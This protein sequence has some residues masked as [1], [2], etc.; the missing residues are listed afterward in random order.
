[1]PTPEC[2]PHADLRRIQG[3]VSGLALWTY[4]LPKGTECSRPAQ[5][6][7]DTPHQSLTVAGAAQELRLKDFKVAHLFP[8]WPL[9]GTVRGTRERAGIL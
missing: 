7:L 1:M 3:P 2:P 4:R 8:V 9:T 6:H 5:W